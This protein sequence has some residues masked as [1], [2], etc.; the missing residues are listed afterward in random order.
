MKISELEKVLARI[1][2]LHGDVEVLHYDALVEE[3]DCESGGLT[4]TFNIDYEHKNKIVVL[5]QGN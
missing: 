5:N 1:K 2:R 4:E 3:K